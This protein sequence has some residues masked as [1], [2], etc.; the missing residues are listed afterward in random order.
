MPVIKV[1]CLPASQTEDNL[2]DLHKA[3]VKAVV[4]QTELGLKDENDMTCL[5]PPDQMQ[6]G[7]GA[8]VIVEVLGLFT[9]PARTW[10]VKQLLAER[11]GDA[12][13]VLYPNAKVEVFVST[14]N[15]NEDG[16]W[17]SE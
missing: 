16:F 9:K 12:V 10:E 11:L 5:F 15:Q 4:A 13:K 17:S 1:W 3:I 7:L 6:Y 8:E 2:R 14:F